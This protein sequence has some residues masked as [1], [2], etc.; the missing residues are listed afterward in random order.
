M[1]NDVSRHKFQD[2]SQL[3]RLEGKHT[4]QTAHCALLPLSS[5]WCQ[6]HLHNCP[7]LSIVALPCVSWLL[8][9][10]PREAPHSLCARLGRDLLFQAQVSTFFFFLVPSGFYNSSKLGGRNSSSVYFTRLASTQKCGSHQIRICHDLPGSKHV[11]R[12]K[13][14][15]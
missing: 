8:K 6:L 11:W 3:V 2:M 15:L 9:L 1:L 10:A 5:T 12:T 4:A 7:H 13:L 14:N